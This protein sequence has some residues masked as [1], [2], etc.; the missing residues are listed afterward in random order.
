MKMRELVGFAQI[1][2]QA[3]IH[4]QALCFQPSDEVFGICPRPAETMAACGI[5]L[6]QQPTLV[7]NKDELCLSSLVTLSSKLLQ[8]R[9]SQ[10]LFLAKKQNC[11][12]AITPVH[13]KNEQKLFH[14][15]MRDKFATSP[16]IDWI[17]FAVLWNRTAN[18]EDLFYKTT[19]ELI[20]Y[21][22]VW[23]EMHAISNSRLMHR[24][25]IDS[26]RQRLQSR[27]RR[28]IAPTA[29]R[30]SRLRVMNAQQSRATGNLFFLYEGFNLVKKLI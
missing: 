19:E 2:D 12:F 13:T 28:V 22:K 3:G 20:H 27:N 10:Y 1:Y 21:E 26:A 29:Q 7:V 24:E 9:N 15:L 8:V 5:V 14:Q 6:Q 30:P 16:R 23:R 18:G 11:K 4:E 25:V 17:E